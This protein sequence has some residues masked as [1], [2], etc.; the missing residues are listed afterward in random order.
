M[1]KRIIIGLSIFALI[2]FAGGIYIISAIEK[3]TSTLDNLI[4]LHQVEITRE[5]LL[6]SVRRAQA[7]LAFRRTRYARSLDTMVS[8]VV[9]MSNQARQC[10]TCHHSE[11][12]TA[13]LNDLGNQIGMYQNSLSR[14]FTIRGDAARS[15]TEEDEAFMVGHRLVSQLN[16]MTMLTK[17]SLEK[18][19]RSTL[20]G[21]NQMKILL[22][23]LISAGPVLAIGLAVIFIKGFTGPLG[24]LLQATRKIKG[25]D[26]SF[27]IQVLKDEFGEVAAS[28]N[29]MAGSLN[30]QMQNMQRAEQMKVVGEMAAGLVHEIKNP[31]AGIKA[32]MQVLLE[33]GNCQEED[34]VILSRVID[35][36]R[37]IESLM[38]SLLDFAKPSKPQLVPVDINGILESALTFSLPYSSAKSNSPKRIEI[39]KSFDPD[40]PATMADPMQMQQV[41]LNLLMNAV[42]AMPEGGTLTVRTSENGSLQGILIEVVDTGKGID[43]EIRGKLFQPFFTTKHKGTGLGLATSRRFVEMHSGT[44]SAEKNP[45]G[46]TIFRIVLPRIQAEDGACA[47]P[48][49]VRS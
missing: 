18:Q 49:P 17:A 41:F 48:L 40:L 26:L 12:V 8:N 20:E 1:K 21:I 28:F 3:A 46:G 4:K 29:D 47:A 7:D 2:F 37:R 25:G 30:E 42:E 44:I 9:S 43:E 14:L 23:I 16:T 45:V 36:A 19:T 6:S 32:S 10:L 31:L 27:R 22:F 15:E 24:A 11:E 35:E 13:K 34:R 39:V 38:K 5:E 33:E